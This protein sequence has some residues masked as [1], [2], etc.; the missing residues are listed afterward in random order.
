[1]HSHICSLPFEILS[2]V[3]ATSV[4]WGIDRF[5]PLCLVM[6]Q[7]IWLWAVWAHSALSGSRFGH[8]LGPGPFGLV[9]DLGCLRHGLLEII[10]R[11]TVWASRALECLGSGLWIVLALAQ[12]PST[13]LHA[14]AS[15]PSRICSLPFGLLSPVG[16]TS[17]HWDIDRLGP[18]WILGPLGCWIV[19]DHWAL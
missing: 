10:G 1:M 3:G 18:N 6:S 15:M 13:C 7:P 14:Y 2:P 9:W 16:A 8:P 5:G 4:H 12:C 17:V 19:W 11:W